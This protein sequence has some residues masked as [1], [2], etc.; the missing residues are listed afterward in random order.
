MGDIMRR[1]VLTAI[2]AIAAVLC[3]SSAAETQLD[4]A[5]ARLDDLRFGSY[6]TSRQVERLATDAAARDR[7]WETIRRMGITRLY[8]EVYRGG[9]VVSTEHLVTVRDWLREKNIDTVGGIA[10]VPGGDFGVRQKGPLGWFNWQNEKTQRDLRNVIRTTAGIFDSFIVDDFLC[11]G[12]VSDESKAAKGQRDWG[13]YRRELLTELSRSVFV[14]P[15][16]KVNPR[17]TMI[18]KYP[19]WY[20][21][22]HLFGYDTETFPKIFD[23]VWVG[24]ETRGAETQRYGFVQPYAGFVNYR[25]LAAVSGRKIGGAWFD[26]GDCAEN[27]FIDQAY[28][29]VLAGAP[30]LTF[31]NFGNLID[32]HPDHEKVAAQ[33]YQLAD[34]AASVRRHP[35]I[36]VPAYKPPNS[37]PAGDMYLMDFLGMLGIPLVPVCEFPESA[38]VILLPA[39]AAA[40]PDLLGHITK[41]RARGARLIFTTNLLTTSPHGRKLARMAG[42]D[43]DLRSEPLRAKLEGTDVTVDLE[44]MLQITAGPGDVL[45]TAGER[46]IALLATSQS[47]GGRIAV[48]NTHTYSQQDFDAVG[49]VLLCPRPLGLLNISGKPLATLRAA[50]DDRVRFAGPSRVTL[51]P[52]G[53]GSC[54]VQNFNAKAVQVTLRMPPD[55][56]LIDA[57]SGSPIV[58]PVRGLT[59]PPRGRVW[60]RNDT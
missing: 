6:A 14:D 30:E 42:I 60:V 20:D 1:A 51:H 37:D 13:T 7:A 45:C 8:L 41:A 40:D 32:G 15:A 23:R 21:R 33:F 2:A 28:M 59:I 22:F 4:K 18:V 44:S 54:V 46:R 48:L 58:K 9:H 16:R 29:S 19:Q 12:D 53:D 55:G 49:E 38:P 27:D 26:H 17:I 56:R 34:L 3:G 31:F 25:W 36:G 10:T 39:Q 52:L 57:F 35:V 47:P 5:R 11:T 50:F 24:T 43:P